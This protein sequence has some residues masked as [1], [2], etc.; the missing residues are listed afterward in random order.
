MELAIDSHVSS[1]IGL[2][3]SEKMSDSETVS[4]LESSL[5]GEHSS[6]GKTHVP[7]YTEEKTRRMKAIDSH[8][9]SSTGLLSENASD[10]DA[11]STLES[12]LL[13]EHSSP[14][15]TCV[16]GY[17]EKEKTRRIKAVDSHVSSSTGLLS[18]NASD[19]ETVST[20]ESSLLGEPFLPGKTHVLGHTYQEKPRKIKDIDSHVSLSNGL[21]SE[22][23]SDLEAV[24]TLESSLLGERSP[25]GITHVPGHTYQEK[26]RKIK[27]TD[28]H[29]S[30][31]TGL[32]SENVIDL[33]TVSTLES[34]L[35]REHSSP[36][37]TQVPGHSHKE[38]T[39]RV[40]DIDSQVS[41]SIEL[42]LSENTSDLEA[43]STV[44]ISVLG[45][46]SSPGKSYVPGYAEK[47]KTRRS[48]R[49]S[50]KS[51]PKAARQRSSSSGA[52][53]RSQGLESSDASDVVELELSERD[54]SGRQMKERPRVKI[55][56]KIDVSVSKDKKPR[57]SGFKNLELPTGVLDKRMKLSCDI[58]GSLNLE[59]ISVQN[60]FHFFPQL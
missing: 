35:L 47:E 3:L 9:S 38:K 4:R 13:G 36:G 15:K 45:E 22:N 39:R 14:A 51:T 56:E 37:K 49:S 19:L 34:S 58:I 55:T 46:H 31:S 1:S 52:S 18:E 25:S 30:F 21:L 29:V 17:N 12:S 7:A 54:D 53:I 20:I 32:L 6:P 50:P 57:P 28:S 40:L 48:S 27:A 59:V 11:V 60:N 10:L 5:L 26:T 24:S 43:V 44:E 2:S 16:P 33:E 8:V 41:S 23:M 42:S